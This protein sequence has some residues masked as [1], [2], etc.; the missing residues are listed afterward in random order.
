MNKFRLSA[1]LW[2]PS[3][4][5]MPSFDLTS[6]T[7]ATVL[8]HLTGVAPGIL[9]GQHLYD[10]LVDILFKMEPRPDNCSPIRPRATVVRLKLPPAEEEGFWE[11]METKA[12]TERRSAVI[13]S[14]NSSLSIGAV[15]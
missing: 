9:D 14:D 5:F 15:M 13:T 3:F 11:E 12:N 1:R 4:T 7:I 10:S 2:T 6:T 8:V